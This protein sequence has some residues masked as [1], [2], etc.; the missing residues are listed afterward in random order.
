MWI[1][2]LGLVQYSLICGYWPETITGIMFLPTKCGLSLPICCAFA[3]ADLLY[4]FDVTL[5]LKTHL[6]PLS[7]LLKPILPSHPFPFLL[8]F[9]KMLL[10]S[11]ME[12]REDT[13]SSL[14][15]VLIHAS[16]FPLSPKFQS[17]STLHI[18]KENHRKKKPF[19][20]SVDLSTALYFHCGY[21]A[22]YHKY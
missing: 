22:K 6:S 10:I 5:L 3:Q 14:P 13:N 7:P 12:S 18:K 2:D 4:S 8:Y 11:Q 15:I 20:K 17:A 9:I 16:N 19:S 1:T 21:Y